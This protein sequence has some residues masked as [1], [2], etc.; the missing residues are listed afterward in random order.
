MSNVAAIFRRELQGFFGHPLAW[1][2]LTLFIS[3]LA[4]FNL[5]FDDVLIGG[6]ASMRHPFRW[7][8]AAFLM[9]IPAITMRLLAEERRTGSIQIL[10]TLPV[11]AAEI[12]I[13]KW[14]AAVALTVVALGFTLSYP[15]AL[16]V[17]GDLDLGPVAAGYVGLALCGAAFAAIGTAA[18]A[19]TQNQVIAFLLA[20]TTCAMPWLVGYS[21]PL[22]PGAWA[23]LV[24]YLTPE[25]HFSNLAR[26]V[27][28]TRS[29]VFFVAVSAVFLRLATQIL[30]HRRLS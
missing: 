4:V 2:V 18:S 5:W 3:I 21:L 25:Y 27:L 28:D 14:L 13:G 30:E 19:L 8:A 11:S 7:I 1:I 17:L 24:E 16:A 15:L 20:F 9:L 23:P 10:V 6:V 12:V 26:G 29:L 22:I